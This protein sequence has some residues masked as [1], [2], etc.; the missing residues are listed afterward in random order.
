MEGLRSGYSQNIHFVE[1]KDLVT[2]PKETMDKLY[3]FIGEE[4]FE[5]QFT[6][7]KNQNR[8][9]DL[10]TYGLNDMHE[11]RPVV[12]ST[13]KDPKKVLSE[14]VLNKCENMDF[15]RPKTI[16]TVINSEKN[17]VTVLNPKLVVD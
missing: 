1:Y 7:L 15:W 16:P 4:P 10:N 3:E 8:E 14:D 12:K 11:V 9:N 13:A 17:K 5:H 2:N 6:N